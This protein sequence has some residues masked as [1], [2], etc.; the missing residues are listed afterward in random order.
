MHAYEENIRAASGVL[1]LAAAII[2]LPLAMLLGIEQW[3]RRQAFDSRW[4]DQYGT[5]TTE[6]AEDDSDHV[7][8]TEGHGSA[9]P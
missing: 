3:N 2:L 7:P 8:A 6:L 4:N 5:M 1:A 9:N